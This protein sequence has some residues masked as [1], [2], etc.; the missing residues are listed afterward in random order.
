MRESEVAHFLSAVASA[1]AY[2]KV[3][4]GT[5]TADYIFYLTHLVSL[6]FFLFLFWTHSILCSPRLPLWSVKAGLPE[7]F[8]LQLEARYITVLISSS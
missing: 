2:E 5:A 3:V 4:C 1:D 6:S 7:M 8:L